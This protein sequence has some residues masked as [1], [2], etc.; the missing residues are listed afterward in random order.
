MALLATGGTTSEQAPT[1]P[2]PAFSVPVVMCTLTLLA[3]VLEGD[4]DGGLTGAYGSKLAALVPSMGA[5]G[6][7]GCCCG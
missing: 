6:S 5:C 1:A 4:V 3:A 7:E 2:S